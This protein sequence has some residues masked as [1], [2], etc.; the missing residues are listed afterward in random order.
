VPDDWPGGVRHRGGMSLVCGSRMEHGKARGRFG[1]ALADRP[2][3]AG[4]P[5]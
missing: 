3:V 4:K 5:L 1:S 2:V